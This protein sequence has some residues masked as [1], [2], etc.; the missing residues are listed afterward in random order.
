[1]LVSV[2]AISKNQ[3]IIHEYIAMLGPRVGKDMRIIYNNK[4]NIHEYIFGAEISI[5]TNEFL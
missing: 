4:N 5:L 1:M 2:F 3:S